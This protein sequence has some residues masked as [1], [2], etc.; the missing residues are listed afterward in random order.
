MS[1]FHNLLLLDILSKTFRYS[2]KALR[3][4]PPAPVSSRDQEKPSESHQVEVSTRVI[5]A[6]LSIIS[7]KKRRGSNRIKR[8]NQVAETDF[9]T[10]SLSATFSQ[11][12][13][14]HK[15]LLLSVYPWNLKKS[16]DEWNNWTAS[17]SQVIW[18]SGQELGNTRWWVHEQSHL[19]GL[20]RLLCF[21]LA[22][23]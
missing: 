6:V 19:W 21:F 18:F 15:N 13:M 2:E 3:K 9:Q 12:W 7:L 22:P 11:V 1:A 14:Q 17:S 10:V 16:A 4:Q 8:Q 20:V 5:N 23:A